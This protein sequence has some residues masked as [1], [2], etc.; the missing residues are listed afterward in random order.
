MEFY[1]VVKIAKLVYVG[2][3][4]L[5]KDD[6]SYDHQKSHCYYE[7]LNIAKNYLDGIKDK[8][9]TEV[10]SII[11]SACQH[12]E[13]AYAT[14]YRSDTKEMNDLILSIIRL[15]YVLDD[16]YSVIQFWTKQIWRALEPDEELKKYI[17]EDDFQSLK[18]NH[19]DYERELRETWEAER[20]S[21]E[22]IQDL[23]DYANSNWGG[24]P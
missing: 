4:Y 18:Y 13:T 19:W 2:V 16:D 15:H 8:R 12:L 10:N 23:L 11:R 22:E 7:S 5:C 14:G 9:P 1:S 17:K 20:E 21:R 24:F 3:T 6:Y